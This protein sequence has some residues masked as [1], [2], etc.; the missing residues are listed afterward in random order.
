MNNLTATPTSFHTGSLVAA[1]IKRRSFLF[2]FLLVLTASAT[3]AQEPSPGGANETRAAASSGGTISGRVTGEG[4]QPL[5]SAVVNI[6]RAYASGPA[7]QQAVSTD[8]EGKFMMTNLSPGLYS[9]SAYAPGFVA[10]PDVVAGSG[11][12]RY[13]RVGDTVNL[14]LTKGG[15]I[16]GTVRDANGEPVV[17]VPVRVMRVRDAAGHVAPYN[18]GFFQSRMTDDRGVYRIYGLTAGTYL[19]STGGSLGFSSLPNFYEGDAPTYYPSSTRDTAVEVPVRPGEEATNIDI[20]YRG[21]RGHVVSGIITGTSEGAGSYSISVSLRQ[22]AS[23]MSESNAF[24]PPSDKH[25]FSIQGVGDGVY[26]LSAQQGNFGGNTLVSPS[27]RITVR[28]ADV[29]GLELTLAPLG[30]IAGRATLE[31]LQKKEGCAGAQEEQRPANLIETIVNARRAEK[32]RDEASPPTPFSFG[33]ISALTEQGEFT[34]RNLGAGSY[35]LTARLP[36]DSWYV[37]SIALPNAA[38]RRVPLPAPK[39]AE[40]KGATSASSLIMLKSGENFSGVTVNI[41]QDGATLR[42][43]VTGAKEAA[44]GAPSVLPSNLRVYLVPVERE[45]ADDTLRYSE[46]K[47]G[48]DGAFSFTN[49]APGHYWLIARPFA[50][51]DVPNRIPR[52]LAWDAEARATL[53]R[54]AEAQNVT[55]ELTPCKRVADQ[56]L[57]YGVGSK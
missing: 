55:V 6:A 49:L 2:L 27:R 52:P 16:T 22:S 28:G 41:A 43:R 12:A 25:A 21:E 37:R 23:G 26:D 29:T 8:E 20:R 9:V 4:G 24:V 40:T 48:D 47:P 1:F 53:R 34:V 36:M 42:G 45:R 14:T 10:S 3:K 57:R 19:V 51:D 33:G 7:Q 31:P 44:E 39:S 17:A 50:E 54:E 11:E 35:R 56:V 15:V 5:A 18:F 46:V 32:S 30:S 13:Y 38:P